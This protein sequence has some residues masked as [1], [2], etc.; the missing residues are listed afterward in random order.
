MLWF[1]PVDEIRDYFGDEIGLYF[2]W[3]GVYTRSLA[4]SSIF[5]VLAMVFGVYTSGTTDPDQNDLTLLYSVFVAVWSVAFLQS[6]ERRERELSFLWGTE[7]LADS[8]EPRL[9]FVGRPKVV[10]FPGKETW[11]K[12]GYATPFLRRCASWALILLMMAATIAVSLIAEGLSSRKNEWWEKFDTSLEDD[13]GYGYIDE[14]ELQKIGE[15]LQ[16]ISKNSFLSDFAAQSSD[17]GKVAAWAEHLMNDTQTGWLSPQREEP[18]CSIMYGQ[19]TR[20]DDPVEDTCD[21]MIDQGFCI[22]NFNATLGIPID[23]DPKL[24]NFGA[25]WKN[26]EYKNSKAKAPM[27]FPRLNEELWVVVAA[28]FN[29]FFL[30]L[31][32]FIFKKMA[33]RLNNWENHRLQSVHNRNLI[34]KLFAFAFVNNYFVMFYIAYFRHLAILPTITIPRIDWGWIQVDGTPN[35]E[36]QRPQKCDESCMGNN[37]G[38]FEPFLHKNEH[39]TKTGSGQT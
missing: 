25:A 33:D 23:P 15:A 13:P 11:V 24:P 1:Q 32:A 30:Q 36:L 18:I 6:W 31:F 2:A 29:L 14:L 28:F 39:F 7:G 37:N 10:G 34:I 3:L 38:N 16:E 17:S 22:S 4:F 5:G 27:F 35:F 19:C 9:E 12:D 26:S 8:Q 21:D 20:S